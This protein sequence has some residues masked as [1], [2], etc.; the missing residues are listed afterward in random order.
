MAIVITTNEDN[1]IPFR[2]K[3]AVDLEISSHFSLA[4]I[5]NFM[6]LPYFETSPY[7]EFHLN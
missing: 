4:L 2:N 3:D 1:K 5:V 7:C 6:S